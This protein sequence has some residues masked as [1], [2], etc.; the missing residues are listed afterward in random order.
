RQPLRLRLHMTSHPFVRRASL[1]FASLCAVSA[2]HA[3]RANVANWSLSNRFADTATMRRVSYSTSVTPNW[4]NGGDSLWYA[5]RD[6]AGCN[7]YVAYP[8]TKAKT[9]L[10]DQSRLAA[11]LS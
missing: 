1:A 2:A 9:A 6:H 4:I 8:R 10:F 11:Q 5:W 3:Q 7:F